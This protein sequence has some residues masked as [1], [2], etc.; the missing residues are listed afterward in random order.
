MS[1]YRDNLARPLPNKQETTQY[2]PK[3]TTA[4]SSP[5]AKR[6]ARE[7]LLWLATILFIV[8]VSLVLVSRYAHMV[9][10][11]YSIEQQKLNLQDAR[12][13]SLKAEQQVLELESPDRIKSFATNKLGMKQ[14]EDNNL[15]IV[16]G[17][18]N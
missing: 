14:A 9:S 7:K 15:V 11:N 17:T 3:K 6:I 10:L 1:T 12:D 16:P 2:A 5:E 18:D 13:K 4:A 8:T